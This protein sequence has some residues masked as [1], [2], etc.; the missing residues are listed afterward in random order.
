MSIVT[1][2]NLLTLVCSL[3]TMVFLIAIIR[4]EGNESEIAQKT[5]TRG[6]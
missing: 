2:F 1:I 3:V 4:R 6:S 5:E